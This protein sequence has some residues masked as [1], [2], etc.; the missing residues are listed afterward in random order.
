M[1]KLYLIYPDA[2]QEGPLTEE[3]VRRR[4]LAGECPAGTTAWCAGMDHRLPVQETLQNLHSSDAPFEEDATSEALPLLD[5]FP[6]KTFCRNIFRL[7]S[8]RE[9]EEI[10]RSSAS[11]A[12]ECPAPWLFSRLLLFFLVWYFGICQVMGF[13]DKTPGLVTAYWIFGGNFALPFCTLF[14]IFECN[15]SRDYPFHRV[16]VILFLGGFVSVAGADVLKFL[17][18]LAGVIEEPVK[19][20]TALL[21]GGMLYRKRILTG[22]LIG[23]AVGTGFAFY[24]SEVYVRREMG[25]GNDLAAAMA[26]LHLRAVTAPFG[27]VLWTALISGAFCRSVDLLK[28][29]GKNFTRFYHAFRV[30]VS[31]SFLRIFGI[32]VLL[33]VAWN[34]GAFGSFLAWPVDAFIGWILFFRILYAGILQVRREQK[35]QGTDGNM[36]AESNPS[37]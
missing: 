35:E 37:I 23:A 15:I 17:K 19:F 9:I 4:L 28:Q 27:H 25:N 13:F 21:M 31:A 12:A 1:N 20:L 2:R 6:F 30:L 22:M 16:L 32:V 24:E 26:V 10:F 33:H 18:E 36:N 7:H 14:L 11:P 29:K 8:I 5:T 3:D 34:I